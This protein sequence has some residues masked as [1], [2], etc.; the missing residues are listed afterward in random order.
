M[1]GDDWRCGVNATRL[2]AAISDELFALG[3]ERGREC[4]R[5][6]FMAGEWPKETGQGG[7]AKYSFRRFLRER[8]LAHG[9]PSAP[10]K[11]GAA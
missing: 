7:L 6:Q 4:R 2:A 1:A 9:V 5:I 8:L 10:K 11:G 3:S